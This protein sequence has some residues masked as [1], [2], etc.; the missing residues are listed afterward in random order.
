MTRELIEW[1]FENGQTEK[2]GHQVAAE[3]A[4]F[5]RRLNRPTISANSELF[6]EKPVQPR[7]RDHG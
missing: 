1:P 6:W 3:E 4:P 5:S 7:E 2:S